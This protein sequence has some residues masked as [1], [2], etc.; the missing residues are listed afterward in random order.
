MAVSFTLGCV[1]IPWTGASSGLIH[2]KLLAG[3]K[4]L[5]E[6]RIR[7]TDD[8]AVG[9]VELCKGGQCDHHTSDGEVKA[10]THEVINLR[11]Y[12]R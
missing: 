7:V 8:N 4:W 2:L 12:S 6:K 11:T 10:E 9:P 5:I 3:E 1:R